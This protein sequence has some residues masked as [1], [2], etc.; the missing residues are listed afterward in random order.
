MEK[1]ESGRNHFFRLMVKRRNRLGMLDVERMNETIASKQ[2]VLTLRRYIE[3]HMAGGMA[4]CGERCNAGQN[5]CILVHHEIELIPDR[6][7]ISSRESKYSFL[8]ILIDC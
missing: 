5:L 8:K 1:P 4:I 3:R 6:R 2:E 7:E